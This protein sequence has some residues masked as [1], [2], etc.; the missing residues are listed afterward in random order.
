M[1]FIDY[2][3]NPLNKIQGEDLRM[4]GYWELNFIPIYFYFE[5]TCVS[6]SA[7]NRMLNQKSKYLKGSLIN[8]QMTVLWKIMNE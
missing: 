6:K 5:K 3:F 2:Y 7:L 4:Y 8:R 1:N